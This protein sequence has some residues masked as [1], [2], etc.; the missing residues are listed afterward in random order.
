VGVV[1]CVV[2]RLRMSS[3]AEKKDI[4]MQSLSHVGRGTQIW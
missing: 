4:G 1:M 2:R 3:I